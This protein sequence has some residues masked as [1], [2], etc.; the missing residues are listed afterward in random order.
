MKLFKTLF[1][2]RLTI[3]VFFMI[4]F[5]P[6]ILSFIRKDILSEKKCPA[7]INQASLFISEDDSDDGCSDEDDSCDDGSDDSYGEED[8][9]DDEGCSDDDESCESAD[10]SSY[11]TYDDDEYY[12]DGCSCGGETVVTSD[13]PPVSFFNSSISISIT[14]S[15]TDIWDLY[16]ETAGG[17]VTKTIFKDAYLH[18]THYETWDGYYGQNQFISEGTYWVVLKSKTT[19]KITDRKSFYYSGSHGF[20]IDNSTENRLYFNH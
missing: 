9:N 17:S 7:K 19:T 18:G 5:R 12:D 8:Y 16:I 6:H 11:D 3:I 14:S 13:N 4:I 20:Q 2:Y 15:N 1:A 10:D